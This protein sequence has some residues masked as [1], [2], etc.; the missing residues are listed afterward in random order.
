MSDPNHLVS[1]TPAIEML[2]RSSSVTKRLTFLSATESRQEHCGYSTSD[3]LQKP[4]PAIKHSRCLHT[5]MY[6]NNNE[7]GV[8]QEYT[9]TGTIA[10]H[11]YVPSFAKNTQNGLQHLVST[12]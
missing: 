4:L 9:C 10:L 2:Y 8:P 11:S 1:Y 3:D 12:T 5:A 6:A 7:E